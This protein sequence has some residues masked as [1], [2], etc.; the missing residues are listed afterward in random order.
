MQEVLRI[1]CG[2][3]ERVAVNVAS[4]PEA[5]PV[6]LTEENLLDILA[7]QPDSIVVDALPA[8]EFSA[9]VREKLDSLMRSAASLR[10]ALRDQ[11]VADLQQQ[12]G[13]FL[14]QLDSAV[15]ILQCYSLQA[16]PALVNRKIGEL[17]DLRQRL[18]LSS[19]DHADNVRCM[20]DLQYGIVPALKAIRKFFER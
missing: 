8:R 11:F 19:F 7:A 3:R 14:A 9:I 10:T 16:G 1:I 20:D 15:L 2:S 13:A 4:S 5:S 17:Q 12:A 18:A 6:V